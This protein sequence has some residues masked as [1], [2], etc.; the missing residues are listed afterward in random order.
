MNRHLPMQKLEKIP[1]DHRF[2]ELLPGD[3][4]EAANRLTQ[5][6]RPE[7]PGQPLGRHLPPAAR[8]H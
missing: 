8:A 2:S 3:F 4:T 7:I 6:D 5:I 1:I